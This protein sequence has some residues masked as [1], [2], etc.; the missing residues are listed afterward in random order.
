MVGMILQKNKSFFWS[1]YS[2]KIR[3]FLKFEFEPMGI[4]NL[5]L[6]IQFT[7]QGLSNKGAANIYSQLI[8]WG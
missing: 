3:T 2:Q 8:F 5:L 7:H 1:A 6:Q 4:P